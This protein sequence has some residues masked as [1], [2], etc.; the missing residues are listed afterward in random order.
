MFSF[1]DAVEEERRVSR[2]VELG[3]TGECCRM[4]N[5]RRPSCGMLEYATPGL[6]E[7]SIGGG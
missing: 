5:L 6:V 7:V 1:E 3:V 4:R 2:L